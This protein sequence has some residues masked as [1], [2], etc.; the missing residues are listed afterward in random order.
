M[1]QVFIN[2]IRSIIIVLVS[3]LFIK[4][5]YHKKIK[6]SKLNV[7][8]LVILFSIIISIQ[9]LYGLK[10][11]KIV[12]SA[13]MFMLLFKYVFNI[14]LH[15]ALLL[16]LVYLFIMS[17]SEIEVFVLFKV[18]NINN[19]Y[20]YD[21]FLASIIGD[22]F[23]LF[24]FFLNVFI[25]KRLL[26]KLLNIKFKWYVLIYLVLLF[27]CLIQFFYVMFGN[28]G[29]NIDFYSGIFVIV[30]IL[31]VV[32]NLF[33]QAYKKNELEIKYDKLLDFIKKYELEI[34]NQRI[35]RHETKNQLLTIKSK[36]IDNDS[37]KNI[38]S[39]INEVIDDND[40]EI[41]YTLY[42]KLKN[43]P[44]NGLRGLFY[45]K[46]NEAQD[47]N[48]NV[49]INISTNLNDSFLLKTKTV[50]FNKLGKILVI[51]LDNAIEASID[52]KEPSIGIE[53]YSKEDKVYFVISNTYIRINTFKGFNRGHGLLLAK[54]IVSTCNK[55]SL[56][57]SITE[58]LYIQQITIK[59]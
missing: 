41:K 46:I 53:I 5:V 43:L 27:L 18:F 56:N 51:I 49:S 42:S 54:N 48:V 59:K 15:E 52:V 38:I 40:R 32:I 57:T 14:N 25:L 39:Y 23:V 45:F 33:Y 3:L 30:V 24:F 7:I 8:L 12:F 34:E 11:L 36:I 21:V 19:S 13:I 16:S 29:T 58:K 26:L 4:Q 28:M 37:S 2:I 1:S 22:I 17:I 20:L 47:H 55:L 35:I 44:S 6:R 10:V 9:I 50:V 31:I